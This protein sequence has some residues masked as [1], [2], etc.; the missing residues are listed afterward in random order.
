ML[1]F[2]GGLIGAR[3]L[4]SSSA[5]SG[6]WFPNEQ[7][8]AKR[9]SSWPGTDIYRYYRLSN[10]ANTS[11]NSNTIDFGEIELYD[12]N[13]KHTG[14]TCTTS[15]TFAAGTAAVLVDGITA[16]V[17][18]RA[19]YPSWSTVQPTATITFDM[20]SAKALTHIKV[21]SLYTQPRF[22][23]SFDLSG[24]T[25]NSSFTFLSTVTVGTSF[26]LVSTNVYSS[27]KVPV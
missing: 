21:F 27:E 1:G 24:S 13:T 23:A 20:G 25:D 12:G 5:A 22:P 10:F 7:S 15:W 16:S 14:I 4:P 19:Y 2:N 26:S 3:N 11:L 9:A 6:L 18:T 17:S 8:V